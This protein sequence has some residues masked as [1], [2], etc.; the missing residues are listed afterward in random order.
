MLLTQSKDITPIVCTGNMMKI[1]TKSSFFIVE[2]E[3][4]TLP[5]GHL[6]MWGTA[7]GEFR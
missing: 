6:A 4:D 3:E 1:V 2:F 7:Q 5:F